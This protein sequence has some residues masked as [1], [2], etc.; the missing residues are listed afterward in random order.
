MVLKPCATGKTT[1]A[2]SRELEEATEP[3]EV[4]L[5]SCLKKRKAEF[6]PEEEEEEEEEEEIE[7]ATEERIV[8]LS[9]SDETDPMAVPEWDVDSF[10]GLEYYS[11]PEPELSSDEQPYENMENAHEHYRIF[12]RQLIDSKG[13]MVDPR[14]RPSYGYKGIRPLSLEGEWAKR[15]TFCEE[16]VSVCLQ[17]YNQEKAKGCSVEFVKVVRINYRAGPRPKSYITFMAREKPD[18]D[19]VEYQAK[20]MAT[21]DGKKHPILCR[22]APIPKP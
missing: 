6:D 11:S 17:K 18:G 20:A 19:L 2:D 16:M 7:G 9:E 12:K 13:F 10:D 21:L 15:I 22:P 5:D 1:E 4:S 3:M 8:E 14:L